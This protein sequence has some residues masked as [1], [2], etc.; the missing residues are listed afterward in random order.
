MLLLSRETY[1]VHPGL[2]VTTY[3][4]LRNFLRLPPT[5]LPASLTAS[6]SAGET[7]AGVA[8]IRLNFVED[9]QSLL[10]LSLKLARLAAVWQGLQLLS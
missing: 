7:S 6:G 8:Y 10:S 3:R 2:A 4:L 9:M 1:L 5:Y